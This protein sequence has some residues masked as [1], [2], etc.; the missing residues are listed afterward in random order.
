MA[1]RADPRVVMMICAD[2]TGQCRA[3]SPR[4]DMKWKERR[5]RRARGVGRGR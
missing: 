3:Y 2:V 1:G 4:K 5:E